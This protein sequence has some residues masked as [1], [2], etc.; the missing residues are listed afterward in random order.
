MTI[1]N[2]IHIIILQRTGIALKPKHE[3]KN[4]N[5]KNSHRLPQPRTEGIKIDVIWA[6]S[7]VQGRHIRL[8][9]QLNC[10]V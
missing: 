4:A 1:Y 9:R 5:H 2:I 8:M 3:I 6:F 10:L 7:S